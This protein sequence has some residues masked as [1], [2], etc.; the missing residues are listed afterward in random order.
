M[1]TE[2]TGL[3]SLCK[4]EV[5]ARAIVVSLPAVADRFLF[6]CQSTHACKVKERP[7]YNIV[8]ILQKVVLL[9]STL[10]EL[11]LTPLLPRSKVSLG[12]TRDLQ[13][14][15]SRSF[16][17]HLLRLVLPFLEPLRSKLIARSLF[18]AAVEILRAVREEVPNWQE[19]LTTLVSASLSFPS[20]L[21]ADLTS[22]PRPRPTLS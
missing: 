9:P 4:L 1:Q 8:S 14:S 10:L 11:W 5:R 12:P 20:L 19:I 22:P 21:R 17:Q 18:T 16:V 7:Y 3:L 15:A 6:D 13:Q 2:L